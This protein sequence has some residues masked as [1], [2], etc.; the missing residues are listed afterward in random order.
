LGMQGHNVTLLAGWVSQKY[1]VWEC[2]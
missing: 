2:C 1:F